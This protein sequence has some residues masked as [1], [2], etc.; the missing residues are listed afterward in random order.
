[1]NKYIYVKQGL[2][3]LCGLFLAILLSPLLLIIAL[4]IKL[5]SKGP[6]L[7]K[8]ERIGKNNQPFKIFKFRTMKTDAPSNQPTHLLKNP[9]AYI[10]KLGTFLR[11]SSL[12][13]L[14]QIFN[15]L[16]GTMSFIGPRPALW[17]QEDL[18]DARTALEISHIKPGI[19]GWAQVN[20]RDELPIA[21]KVVYD[22][23]YMDKLSFK[24]DV[25]ILLKTIKNV[26]KS[27]GIIEGEH[28]TDTSF[29]EFELNELVSVIIP[30]YRRSES[31]LG[32]A[33]SSVLN[34]TY[35]NIEV[36]VI[37]DN[38]GPENTEFRQ[39]TAQCIKQYNDS[40]IIYIQNEVNEG[41]SSNRNYGINI[42]KGTY[43]C[44]LDDDDT[45]LPEKIER[46]LSYML[47]HQLDAC[48]SNLKYS[49]EKGEVIDVREHEKL[50]HLDHK[51]LLQYHITRHITG[52]PTFMYKKD[53]LIQIGGF[54]N[55]N[56]AEEYQ[57]MLMT[58]EGDYK[59]G[60]LPRMDVIAYRHRSS[61]LSSGRDKLLGEKA[62]YKCKKKY[63]SKLTF[64]QRLFVCFR[65]NV[66]M[67]ISHKRNKHYIRSLCYLIL[68]V[69][70]SPMDAIEEVYCLLHNIRIY[71]NKLKS[72]LNEGR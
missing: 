42:A 38:A 50:Q 27:E 40:R 9:E 39:A 41:V 2:D 17:N 7:F 11:K 3:L 16:N 14:P 25:R 12:D 18:I 28:L 8:Q 48:F 37:D 24:M 45:F 57:L 26:L 54:P 29:T 67:G 61:G 49:N 71:S 68:A 4:S 1:M 51:S 6:V 15:V 22:K 47:K 35:S 66:V 46:Q 53:V 31:F 23:E 19:T 70:V 64:H 33:I 13:E 10:T 32:R 20:G 43:I 59:I 58:I 62:L 21:T 56:I 5:D 52:T 36:I 63:F 55:Q 30:T 60:Y 34:Q 72:P 44:F 69:L 65:H